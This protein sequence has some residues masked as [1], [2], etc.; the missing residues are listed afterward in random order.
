MKLKSM[1]CMLFGLAGLVSAA[2]EATYYVA[3]NGNDASSGTLAQPLATLN[4]ARLKVRQEIAKGLNQP[5]TALIRGGE[6]TLDKTVVFS[7]ED[8]GTEKCPITYRAYPDEKPVFTGG[9]KLSGWKKVAQD[10]AGTSA[11]AKGKLWVCDIPSALRGQWQITSL[12]DGLKLLKRSKSGELKASKEQVNDRWNAQPKKMN[13]GKLG[14][15]PGDQIAFK[16]D[17]YYRG[18]DL[19]AWE[20]LSDIEILTSPKNGWLVN[21]LPLES[22]DTST[23]IATYGI[24]STYTMVPN[25]KYYI[26]NAIDHLDEAGEWVFNSLEGRIYIWPEGPLDKADIRAPYLQEFIKVEGVEDKGK[27]AYLVFDGLTFRHGLRDTWLPGDK[28]LQHD[29]EMYDKGNAIL[30]FRHAEE[31]AVKSCVFEASSGS[32]IRVDLYGQ[33]IEISNNLFAHLGGTGILLSGYAP[34]TKDENKYNKITNNYLHHI[35]T[36]YSH[37]PA[38]F[39]A[40][41]GH[42]LISRNT[43]HDLG[44]NG[45]VISGCRPG[46]MTLASVI[47]HRREWIS[48]LRMDE[49]EACLGRKVTPD[50][51]LTIDDLEPLFHARNNHITENEIYRVM[52]EL[53]DG[54]GIYFSGMGNHN[55][56]E[57]NYLHD[58]GGARG[59]IR[60]DDHSGP[61]VIKNNVGVRT[62]MMFV[63]KGP[64][65]Y[66]NNFS[67]DCARMTNKRWADTQLDQMVYYVTP[68]MKAN[69]KKKSGGFVFDDFERVSNCLI[70]A[71]KA[72][73]QALLGKDMIAKDRRG[74]A[75]VGMLYADPLFDKA[76]MKQKIFR[77]KP[78]SPAEKLGIQPID[79][80]KV[81]ST[82][83][84]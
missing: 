14:Y 31:C 38:I 7:H 63:M 18:N 62:S 24:D 70:F 33:H 74:G 15:K 19:R 1:I 22:I 45:I 54:N 37:S 58:I 5:V 35:G 82:L 76:A 4:G 64:G 6:Y 30:R 52:L 41:S 51:K 72:I 57:R 32:G 8:S 10:P 60:L 29:W 65:E 40:Q 28:S 16:R 73:D 71:P 50:S 17:L 39:I 9:I 43:I 78:G 42:N 77:F 56:A 67:I 79:L 23:R 26:E 2:E 36:I 25:N 59:Y 81:G 83:A 3:P 47:P 68:A 55:V 48:S 69:I 11:A 80:S 61:T 13:L 21:Y 34:G 27:A 49:I 53:H 12:Y 20:N 46:F 66:L 84:N 75:A 44:Y